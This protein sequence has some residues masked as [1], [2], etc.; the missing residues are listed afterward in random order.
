MK[1]SKVILVNFYMYFVLSF[2]LMLFIYDY[3]L[4]YWG[5]DNFFMI[6]LF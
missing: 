1:L 2:C 3:Y 6:K 5:L 4:V